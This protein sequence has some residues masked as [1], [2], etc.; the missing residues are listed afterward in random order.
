MISSI[1]IYYMRN[2]QGMISEMGRVNSE[3]TPGMC[4]L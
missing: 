3:D 2:Q 1:E 4:Y